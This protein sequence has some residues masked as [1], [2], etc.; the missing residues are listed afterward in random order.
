MEVEA[1][2]AATAAGLQNISGLEH[3]ME[4]NIS[5]LEHENEEMRVRYQAEAGVAKKAADDAA[6]VMVDVHK[7]AL[8]QV[9]TPS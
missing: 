5:R 6:Q 3:E 8:A 1:Q 7:T 4:A 2:K 9:R